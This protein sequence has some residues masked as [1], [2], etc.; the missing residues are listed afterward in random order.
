[1]FHHTSTGA[2]GSDAES[3][4]RC[5]GFDL[6]DRNIIRAWKEEFDI[7]ETRFFRE[8]EALGEGFVEDEWAGGGFGNLAESDCGAHSNSEF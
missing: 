1:M 7:I 5:E 3:V 8:G 4:T 6:I 2:Y